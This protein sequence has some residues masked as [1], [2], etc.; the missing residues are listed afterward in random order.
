MMIM[1]CLW[2]ALPVSFI[3]TTCLLQCSHDSKLAS[4]EVD[5]FL[6]LCLSFYECVNIPNHFSSLAMQ[7][8]STT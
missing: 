1:V 4:F 2:F 6:K 5:Q 7:H 8:F 3:A